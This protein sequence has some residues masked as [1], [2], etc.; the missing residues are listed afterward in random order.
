[1][2]HSIKGAARSTARECEP[3]VILSNWAHPDGEVATRLARE[4]GVPS[5]IMVGGSDVLVQTQSAARRRVIIRTLM[6]ADHVV[7]VSEDIRRVICG[8]G[9]DGTRVTCIYRGV[10]QTRFTAM[11]QTDAR[12][13]VG[14]EGATPVLLY[15]GNLLAIKGVDVLLRAAAR[16]RDAGRRFHLYVAGD[17]SER[18]ALSALCAALSLGE[19][20]TF[21][22][23]VANDVLPS[24]Y[25]AANLTVLASHSEGVPNV[26][27]ESVACGT[28]FVATRVGG[29][30]EVASA[31]AGTWLRRT[32]PRDWPLPSPRLSITHVAP[33]SFA[34]RG[35]PR[36]PNQRS[37]SLA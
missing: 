9:I 24:W 5:V 10:D 23:Q 18:N 22:G 13:A 1:M 36:R 7:T 37:A 33:G 25:T 17:G 8:F 31:A 29:I 30:P 21:L 28:P 4:L 16:L 32:I 15:V 2:W 35:R 27:A 34:A 6:R 14:I 26:L 12:R 3:D 11:P 19:H 20:M